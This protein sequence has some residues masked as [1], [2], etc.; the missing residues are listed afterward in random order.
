MFCKNTIELFIFSNLKAITGK[1][2]GAYFNAVYESGHGR[3]GK[4][5]LPRKTWFKLK[6]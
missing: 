1:E 3:D 5:E 4:T 6:S 2:Y